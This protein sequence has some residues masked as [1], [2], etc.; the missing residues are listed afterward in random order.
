LGKQVL[1]L[2][3]ARFGRDRPNCVWSLN[4]LANV[5]KNQGKYAQAEGL[6]QRAL[7]I[8]EK[9]L[10]AAH[11][12]VAQT[13]NGLANVYYHQ[14]KYAQAEG[15]YQRALAIGEKTLGANHPDVAGIL[16]NLAYVYRAQGKYGQAEGLY[17]RALAIKEKELGAG[18]PDLATTLY[19]LALVY[20]AQGKYAQ[21][22]E[23]Y[24]RALAIWEKKLGADH[25]NCAWALHMLAFVYQNEGKYA[26]AEGLHQRALVIRE[27]ALGAGHPD[28]A[29]SLNNLAIV[30]AAS[31]N[32]AQALAFSRKASAAVIAHAASGA[33]QRWGARGL[34]EQ[35]ADYFRRHVANLAVAARL[36][37]EPEPAV[38][39][40]ALEIAQW[41]GQSSAAAA[42]QQMAARFAGGGALG[43]L[44]RE[45]QDLS[46]VW[47]DKDKNLIDA[48]S[49][50]EGQQNPAAIDALRREIAETESKLRVIAAR[51]EREFPDFA[52]LID[53]KPLRA[54]E[55]QNLLGEDEALVFFL[56]GYDAGYVFALS[57]D[58]FAWRS[59]AVGWKALADNV[60]A[61][62]RSLDVSQLTRAAERATTPEPFNL[63]GAHELYITLFSA[64]EPLI[65]DKRH[66]LIVPSG[67]LT[68]LPFHLLVT[69]KPPVAVPE[70]PSQYRDAAWLLKRHAISVLPS[71]ASLKALRQFAKTSS[72]PKSYI[73]FGNPLLLGPDGS[74]TGAW[75]RQQCPKDAPRVAEATR[76]A[77]PLPGISGL[78]RGNLA[79]VAEVQKL[80]ALPETADELCAVARQL[81]VPESEIWL[82][83]RATEGNIK[84]MSEQGRLK[85]YGILHFATH[86]LVSGELKGIAEPALVLTPP[87]EASET[88]DGL[89]TASEVAQ[90][91]L[92]AD[93][94]VL[95]ACNTAAAGAQGTEALSGL[96]RA[97]F[98]AGAR[99]L[100][101]SHWRVNSDA[102]VRLTTKAFAELRANPKI[103]RAE[104]MRRSML[105][106]IT[107]GA[108][109]EVHPAYWGPFSLVGEGGG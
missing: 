45:S 71:V 66:L 74:D 83:K 87:A 81:G 50:P 52:A 11:P 61:F 89:L 82:G 27:K 105:H 57:R 54:T 2:C 78:F 4:N 106:V 17:Q 98:Y 58:A 36:G 21:A 26:Q 65:K 30:Y 14:G 51:L 77:T 92:N 69:Q 95:S 19:N 70:S 107:R 53:P 49:K 109:Q 103:G 9:A 43:A 46:A 63:G 99:A 25:P 16:D 62:R 13:L 15:L 1:D 76:A 47:R 38:G 39:R 32:S 88:D 91:K 108:D 7:A 22:E 56:T 18:H 8:E 48:V 90:L 86:G 100:L 94:V 33:S 23:L 55:L 24:Q 75:D 73:A 84:Q 31:G 37:L 35:R 6:H 80:I 28:V 102:A 34:S 41:A 93:W 64:V 42:V 72:A 60:A 40:E 96:A 68:P 20:H 44:V 97:F 10:G 79:D 5:Y 12:T 59:L 67:P 104:A 101:A 85:S 29:Q 3:E